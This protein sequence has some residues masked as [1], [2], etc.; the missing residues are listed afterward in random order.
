MDPHNDR[1]FINMWI[2][3]YI[4]IYIYMH[5][6]IYVCVCVWCTPLHNLSIYIPCL[7]FSLVWFY[8]FKGGAK[9]RL[10]E[11]WGRLR[12]LRDSKLASNESIGKHAHRHPHRHTHTD[13]RMVDDDGECLDRRHRWAQLKHQQKKPRRNPGRVMKENIA[14]ALRTTFLSLGVCCIAMCRGVRWTRPSKTSKMLSHFNVGLQ[15]APLCRRFTVVFL[16]MGSSQQRCC[17]VAWIIFEIKTRV[18]YIFASRTPG[19]IS[20]VES[21]DLQRQKVRS[22]LGVSA[23][24]SGY[25]SLATPRLPQVQRHVWV[26]NAI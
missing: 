3:A 14:F 4:Y 2:Y 9:D 25:G 17:D 1:Q 6:C 8:W 10:K 22:C 19:S 12:V 11:G 16:S 5:I 15:M 20:W 24:G 18:K 13:G 26:T 23:A 21:C 7:K